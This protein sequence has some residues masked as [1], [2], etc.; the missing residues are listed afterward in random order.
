MTP[1]WS[2]TPT[3]FQI[4]GGTSKTQPE[5]FLAMSI[6][7]DSSLAPVSMYQSGRSQMENANKWHQKAMV[8]GGWSTSSPSSHLYTLIFPIW[9]RISM[10]P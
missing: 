3:A 10:A 1:V 2:E 7:K 6:F 9:F 8:I 5:I 4:D